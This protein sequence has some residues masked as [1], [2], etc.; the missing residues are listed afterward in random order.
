MEQFLNSK[1]HKPY[2]YDELYK[3]VIEKMQEKQREEEEKKKR[4]EQEGEK[5]NGGWDDYMEKRGGSD[6]W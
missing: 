3:F 4:R 1:Y 6:A 5:K 2:K